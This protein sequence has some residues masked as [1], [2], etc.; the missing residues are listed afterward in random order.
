MTT[1]VYKDGKMLSDS[2]AY[3]G[4]SF[5]IGEKHKIQR[6]TDGRLLGVSSNRVGMSGIVAKWIEE[7]MPLD[8]PPMERNKDTFEAILVD[9]DHLYYINGDWMPALV[10]TNYMAIGTGSEY[11]LAALLLGNSPAVAIATAIKLDIWSDFPIYEFSL[12]DTAVKTITEED[13]KWDHN[14]PWL[15]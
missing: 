2:R 9:A 10:H 4:G 12:A 8:K 14:T 11:A 6:L 15:R 7:D 3:S 13:M 1:I 5:P